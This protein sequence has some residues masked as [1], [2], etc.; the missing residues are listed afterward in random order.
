MSFSILNRVIVCTKFWHNFFIRTKFNPKE[1]FLS[2]RYNSNPSAL[3][4]KDTNDTC[5]A[6]IA[7]IN[8]K[9]N[10]HNNSIDKDKKFG[11]I[12]YKIFLLWYIL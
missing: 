9:R 2:Q 10:T 12:V 7:Y 4:R 1:I 3:R 8:F 11:G 5:E 6:S